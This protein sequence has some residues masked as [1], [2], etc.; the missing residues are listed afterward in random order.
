VAQRASLTTRAATVTVPSAKDWPGQ[1]GLRIG[2]P[3]EEGIDTVG[4]KGC[5][6][7]IHM[8]F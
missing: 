4:R 7:R 5:G 6:S 1:N 3:D 2:K 8:R